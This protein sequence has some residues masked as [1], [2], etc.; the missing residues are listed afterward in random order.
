MSD[1]NYAKFVRR[2]GVVVGKE[3]RKAGLKPQRYDGAILDDGTLVFTVD[4]AG[5]AKELH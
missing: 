2:V 5:E 1:V 4:M 3:A